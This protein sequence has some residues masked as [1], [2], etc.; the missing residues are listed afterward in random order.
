[1]TDLWSGRAEAYAESDTHREGRDL[2]LLVS[3]AEGKTALDVA[4]GGG[5]VARRLRDRGFQVTTLDPAPGMRADVLA[6]AEHIPFADESFDTVATR[7]APHHFSD[8]R[9]ATGEMARVARRVVLVED[10]LYDDD[11][12]EEAERL[13][14]PTHVRSYS[15]QEWRSF[16]EDAGLR[17]EEVELQQK[18]RDFVA[19]CERTGCT[20]AERERVR[21]LLGDRVD[22]QGGYT[23]TK[24]LIRARKA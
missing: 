19:W 11:D 18:R 2:D 24:I 7:I 14:D 6:P 16:L 20:A 1:M 12:V 23:D 8:I 15:E 17:V 9:A 3:W 22:A 13:H 4:T 10:T 5:H 21:E